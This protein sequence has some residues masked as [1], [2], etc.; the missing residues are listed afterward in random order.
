MNT[1]RAVK[2][3]VANLASW[4]IEWSK[5]GV[6]RGRICE[7][8]ADEGEALHWVYQL[9]RIEARNRGRLRG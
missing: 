3:P 1:Y 9:A 5:S 7:G 4:D 6:V 8:F 2:T